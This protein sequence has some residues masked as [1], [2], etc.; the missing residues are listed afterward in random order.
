[1]HVSIWAFRRKSE[2]KSERQ[3]SVWRTAFNEN[4]NTK[5]ACRLQSLFYDAVLPSRHYMES[6][7]IALVICEGTYCVV[8][9]TGSATV[10][11]RYAT[12]YIQQNHCVKYMSKILYWFT[13]SYMNIAL[14]LSVVFKGFAIFC[15]FPGT[16]WLFVGIASVAFVFFL[17]L[18]PETKGTRLEDV[19]ELFA[20]PWCV[21]GE[22]DKSRKANS[23]SWYII[24]RKSVGNK[25][26]SCDF[27]FCLTLNKE[28]V[29]E[30][31]HMFSCVQVKGTAFPC[32]TVKG[33][34]SSP[35]HKALIRIICK[36]HLD[37]FQ[38]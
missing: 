19:E 11:V 24:L 16:Y 35:G 21:C 32:L 8:I 18:L 3:T 4:I 33:N 7:N 22:T 27:Y 37:K 30:L 10:D 13:L 6:W 14:F 5:F 9:M 15:L 1:M 34:D 26:Y 38:K 29:H 20:K 31:Q 25:Q 36:H 17:V 23:T 2:I 12:V 28:L